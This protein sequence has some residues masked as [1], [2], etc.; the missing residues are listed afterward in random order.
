MRR[1]AREQ[2]RVFAGAP[3]TPQE[4]GGGVCTSSFVSSLGL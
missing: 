3:H 2:N 4:E 1:H